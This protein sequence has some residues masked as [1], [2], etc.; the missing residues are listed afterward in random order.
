VVHSTSAST[1]HSSSFELPELSSPRPSESLGNEF[2]AHFSSAGNG[3]NTTGSGAGR[4][5]SLAEENETPSIAT[6]IGTV[7]PAVSNTGS[8]I[9]SSPAS[10]GS[11]ASQAEETGSTSGAKSSLS[12]DISGIFHRKDGETLAQYGDRFDKS[13]KPL[14]VP[15][16]ALQQLTGM[17]GVGITAANYALAESHDSTSGQSSSTDAQGADNQQGATATA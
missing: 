3:S 4:L 15:L 8:N 1:S 11:A 12:S 14:T 9:G 16:G 17:A 7:T 2:A 6:H 5:S 13:L 10:I